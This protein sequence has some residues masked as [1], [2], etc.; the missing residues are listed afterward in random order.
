MTKED[1]IDLDH[2]NLELKILDLEYKM[3]L[4]KYQDDEERFL[5][6]VSSIVDSAT[7]LIENKLVIM[8]SVHNSK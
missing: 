2:I 8:L 3:Y 7:R 6:S 4:N 1:Q 5:E